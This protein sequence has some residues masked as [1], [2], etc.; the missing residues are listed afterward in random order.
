MLLSPSFDTSDSAAIAVYGAY[1]P[2][3]RLP[4]SR[5]SLPASN[6]ST[7]HLPP[8]IADELSQQYYLGYP[9]TGQKDGR[10][11]SIRVELRNRAYRVRARKGYVAS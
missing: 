5:F 7:S 4:I 11:H 2:T 8:P 1:A 9:S 10:W 3:R 6:L